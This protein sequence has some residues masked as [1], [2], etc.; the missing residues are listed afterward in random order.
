VEN[1]AISPQIEPRPFASTSFTFHYSPITLILEVTYSELLTASCLRSVGLAVPLCRT[2]SP[3]P[4]FPTSASSL[5]NE[6]QFQA[7]DSHHPFPCNGLRIPWD[8]SRRYFLSSR[9]EHGFFLTKRSLFDLANCDI[10]VWFRKVFLTNS[11]YSI[12]TG[13]GW[14]SCSVSL[15]ESVRPHI[16]QL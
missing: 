16:L 3:S 10:V 7:E 4:W 15:V 11:C 1:D 8:W 12:S 13:S 2:I 14:S 6:V 5:L 9:M